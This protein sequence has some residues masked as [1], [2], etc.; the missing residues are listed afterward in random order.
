MLEDVLD[1]SYKL[2]IDDYGVMVERAKVIEAIDQQL[3]MAAAQFIIEGSAHTEEI[4]AKGQLDL[5][6]MS[7]PARKRQKP[8]L[9]T[10]NP[11]NTESQAG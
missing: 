2:W 9:V 1:F 7:P 3:E 4:L 10:E 6:S 8:K 11:G 5:M